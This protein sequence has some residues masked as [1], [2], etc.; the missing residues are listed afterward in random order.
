MYYSVKL[1]VSKT[2]ITLQYT[3]YKHSE[4]VNVFTYTI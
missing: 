4:C 1:Q 2:H 3:M